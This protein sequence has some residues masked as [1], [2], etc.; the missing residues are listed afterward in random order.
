MTNTH[1]GP[2]VYVVSK[3]YLARAIAPALPEPAHALCINLTG[4]FRFTYPRGLTFAQYPTLREPMYA[5]RDDPPPVYVIADGQARCAELD[6]MSLAEA[7][8]TFHYVGDGTPR[9]LVALWLLCNKCAPRARVSV[10]ILLDMSPAAIEGGLGA[11]RLDLPGSFAL[12]PASAN[13]AV[14][15]VV[16]DALAAGLGKRFFDFN[17]NANSLAI[18]GH[19]VR[20]AGAPN[21]ARVSKFGLQLLYYVRDRGALTDSDLI[22]AMSEW[23]G[24]GKY[25]PAHLGSAASRAEIINSLESSELLKRNSGALE[26]TPT[27]QRF[28]ELLHPDCRDPD[29]PSRLSSWTDTW[30][31]S[32][33]AMER[34]LVKVFDRQLRFAGLR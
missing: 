15:R 11:K 4:Y 21:R 25:P 12:E 5:L 6:W 8:G 33:P 3:P 32:R 23:D 10:S 29:L 13:C 22:K 1:N 14:P 16:S 20:R 24:T 17:W 30:P 18:F 31:E 7:A 9:E 28:L 27:G 19:A 26:I 2:V 34:Y